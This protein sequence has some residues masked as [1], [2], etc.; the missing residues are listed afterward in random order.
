MYI[1]SKWEKHS[2]CPNSHA[3]SQDCNSEPKEDGHHYLRQGQAFKEGNGFKTR[4]P[5]WV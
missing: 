1:V 3:N 5:D 4:L 2:D